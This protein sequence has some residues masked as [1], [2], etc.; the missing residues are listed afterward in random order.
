MLSVF[1][2]G[3]SAMCIIAHALY[4]CVRTRVLRYDSSSPPFDFSRPLY[5][6]PSEEKEATERAAADDRVQRRRVFAV[7]PDLTR[8]E[9]KSPSELPDDVTFF[10]V[11]YSVRGE[12]YRLARHSVTIPQCCAA[13][14]ASRT[15]AEASVV[16]FVVEVRIDDTDSLGRLRTRWMDIEDA[17]DILD[18]YA[19]PL[20]TFDGNECS[21]AEIVASELASQER[22]P[23]IFTGKNAATPEDIISVRVRY[24]SSSGST[25][26]PWLVDL[27]ASNP[28]PELSYAAF[29]HQSRVDKL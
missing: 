16:D 25:E 9:V 24:M 7:L 22:V 1:L 27:D 14:S 6:S 29:L 5:L 13:S 21:L 20:G 12:T 4:V 19:G 28:S 26:A 15:D 3:V 2:T 18:M 23:R 10:V 17:G 8:V 11:E